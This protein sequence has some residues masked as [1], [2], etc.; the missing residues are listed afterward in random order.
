MKVKSIFEKASAIAV[1]IFFFY[2][3]FLVNIRP[4][5]IS[6]YQ[7]FS[8]ASLHEVCIFFGFI[9]FCLIT[10][11][12]IFWILADD[13]EIEELEKKQEKERREEI[14]LNK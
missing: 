12:L 13:E 2:H 7:K 11:R 4:V 1:I 9:T 10:F 5:I 14:L 3:F 6:L 8:K